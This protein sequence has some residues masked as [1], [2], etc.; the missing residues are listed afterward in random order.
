MYICI[1]KYIYFGNIY[2]M[3]IYT[4]TCIYVL[5]IWIGKPSYVQYLF[6]SSVIVL[7]YPRYT[8]VT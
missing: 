1:Y 5:W 2:M 6:R 3:Y 7:F 8:F 4:Y